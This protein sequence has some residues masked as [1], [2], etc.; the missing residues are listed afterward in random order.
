[1]NHFFPVVGLGEID[2]EDFFATFTAE[3]ADKLG[4]IPH[5]R[6]LDGVDVERSESDTAE[7][8]P[9]DI[10]KKTV[11]VESKQMI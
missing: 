10:S 3:E 6:L 11:V 5:R 9:K 4:V 2:E 8:E 1:L 7:E